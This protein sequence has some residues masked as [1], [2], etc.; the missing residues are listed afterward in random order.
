MDIGAWRAT[1]RGITNTWTRLSDFHFQGMSLQRERNSCEL[2]T[3][4]SF[5]F[6]ASWLT[7][8]KRT[9]LPMKEIPV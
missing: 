1:A 5:I 3:F 4:Y 8:W 2:G 7:Q 9:C 6:L